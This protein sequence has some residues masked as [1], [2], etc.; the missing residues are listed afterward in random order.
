MAKGMY[1]YVCV[2][3]HRCAHEGEG[4]G[5]RV[6]YFNLPRHPLT[7]RIGDLLTHSVLAIEGLVLVP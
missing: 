4:E 7:S 2:H 3:V 5:E 6:C 1:T